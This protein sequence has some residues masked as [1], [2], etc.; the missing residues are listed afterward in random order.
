MNDKRTNVW[1]YG[2][3]VQTAAIAVA[4]ARDLLPRPELVVMADTGRERAATW[5]VYT[6]HVEPLFEELEIKFTIAS[7]DL[8]TVDL[9]GYNGDL[10]L[11][12]W[13][14]NGKL[15]TFCSSEWKKYVVR[16]HLRNLGYGPSK[17]VR[18]WFGMARDEVHRL[19]DSDVQWIENYYPLALDLRWSTHDCLNAI[20]D[21]GWPR[22]WPKS[23][24]W[25]CPH[26][27]NKQ[28][29]EI[30]DN[31]PEDWLKAVDLDEYIRQ[32][33]RS[34]DVYLHRS[35]KPLAEADLSDNQPELPLLECRNSCWT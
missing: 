10:L 22:N 4:I 13:T 3:G 15:P 2:G 34:N 17:P 7:H 27:S 6:R 16:R 20:E 28:W 9:Y 33:D 19:R 5:R 23:A 31:D 29:R 35:G 21:F 24:C 30:R 32:Q 26:Y 11:P 18:M 14:S 12:A 25:M 8:A 1:S